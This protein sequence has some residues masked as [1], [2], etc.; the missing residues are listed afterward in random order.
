MRS[1]LKNEV[2]ETLYRAE[3]HTS[4]SVTQLLVLYTCETVRRQEPRHDESLWNVILSTVIIRHL[5]FFREKEGRN[6]R[7]LFVG[8]KSNIIFT[9]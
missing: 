2:L 5:D 1:T 6:M 7:L 4:K 3:L 9:K 8:G